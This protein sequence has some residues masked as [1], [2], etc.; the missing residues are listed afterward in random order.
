MEFAS[1]C[2]SVIRSGLSGASREPKLSSVCL[3]PVG[4][5]LASVCTPMKTQMKTMDQAMDQVKTMDQTM[6][7]IKTTDKTLDQM[8]TIDQ[9][10]DQLKTKDNGQDEDD[11]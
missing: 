10:M 6:D 3:S 11:R 4:D 8:N 5:K 1:V 2:L 9:T 7:Q